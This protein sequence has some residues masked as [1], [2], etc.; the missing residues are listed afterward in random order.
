M[1]RPTLVVLAA[2]TIAAVTDCGSAPATH[3]A[4]PTA[5]VSHAAIGGGT[6]NNG[7][8]ACIG[9]THSLPVGANVCYWAAR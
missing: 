2:A 7:T 4:K 5:P 3:V 9:A 1:T 8:P 6:V